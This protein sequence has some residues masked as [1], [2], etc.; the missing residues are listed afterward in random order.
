MA[1]ES[2]TKFKTLVGA[3]NWPDYKF[4]IEVHMQRKQI[5]KSIM[6]TKPAPVHPGPNATRGEL[7]VYEADLDKHELA[8]FTAMDI[9]SQS[10]SDDI[11]HQIRG[12]KSAKAIWDF[13]V[14]AYKQ[15]CE[16]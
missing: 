15:K 9:F 5:W 12:M 6:G 10:V 16:H 1:E 3:S 2:K 14:T 4:Q 7:R 11:L 13:L 8:N